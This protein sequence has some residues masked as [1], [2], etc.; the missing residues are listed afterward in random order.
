M[1]T[2]LTTEPGLRP[3]DW[4]HSPVHRLSQAGAYMVTAGTYQKQKF[5][6]TPALLT[7]LTNTILQR[8]EMY[9]WNLQ[10]WAIFPNHYHFLAEPHN[11]NTLPRMIREI[12]SLSAHHLNKEQAIQ[13][14]K[15]WFQYWDTQITFHRSFLARLHY[16]HFNP[17]HHGLISNA[18][19]YPWCSAGWFERKAP[20]AFAK[21]VLSFPMNQVAVPDEFGDLLS[22]QKRR[23]A[24]ALQKE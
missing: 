10:A 11:P 3:R 12:H 16:V 14:R 2:E 18:S 22:L 17:V 19:D 8:A 21:T 1:A 24:A 5:F 23:Q 4:P 13:D 9:G 20:P 15:V 6:N 7:E